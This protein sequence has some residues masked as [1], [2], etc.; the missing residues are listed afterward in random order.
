MKASGRSRPSPGFTLIELLVVVALIAILAGLLI[1][2]V[3]N[4]M[5]KGRITEALNNGRSIHQSLA[6]SEIDRGSLWPASGGPE[7]FK[8]STDY[9][10]WAVSNKTLEVTFDFFAAYRVPKAHG[11]DPSRF[12]AENN[13]W[14]IVADVAE[15]T[16]SATPVLFTR[17]LEID[18]LDSATNALSLA[19]TTPFGKRALVVVTRCGA[20]KP[21]R[22]EELADQFNPAGAKNKV[23]RP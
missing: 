14:C 1:P 3:Q 10:K 8:T 21:L 9:W 7:A 16:H 22:E 20:A 11:V 23:L 13:A 18:A 4:A 5:V 2:V 12:T 15:S 6:A 19:E 17:N